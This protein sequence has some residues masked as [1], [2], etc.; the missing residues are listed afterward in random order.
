MT[1]LPQVGLLH[2]FGLN[3]NKVDETKPINIKLTS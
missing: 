1:N 2:L 3:N